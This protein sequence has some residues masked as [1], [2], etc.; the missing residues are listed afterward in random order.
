MLLSTR[1]DRVLDTATGLMPLGM[2]VLQNNV[3]NILDLTQFQ[4]TVQSLI[5]KQK[6]AILCLWR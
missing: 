6:S 3:R 1:L 2:W 4:S 5:W